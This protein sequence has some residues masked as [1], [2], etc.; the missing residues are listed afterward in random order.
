VEEMLLRR[1]PPNP[2]GQ[3]RPAAAR[4]AWNGK[5]NFGIPFS[6]FQKREVGVLNPLGTFSF[7]FER[8]NIFIYFWANPSCTAKYAGPDLNKFNL[9]EEKPSSVCLAN[10]IL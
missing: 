5:G 1:P 10:F 8:R 7:F 6:V 9:K 2:P 4:T 3:Y